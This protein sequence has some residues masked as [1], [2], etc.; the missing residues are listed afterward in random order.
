ME[1]TADPSTAPIIMGTPLCWDGAAV[2]VEDALGLVLARFVGLAVSVGTRA[3]GEFGIGWSSGTS[4]LLDFSAL[5]S[6]Y[7][8]T[9]V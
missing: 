1:A 2:A 7:D 6:M 8:A 3:E 5:K 4:A 9:H